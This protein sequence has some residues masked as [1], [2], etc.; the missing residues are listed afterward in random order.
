MCI[1]GK[2]VAILKMYLQHDKSYEDTVKL[3]K[4]CVEYLQERIHDSIAVGKTK[5]AQVFFKPVIKNWCMEKCGIRVCPSYK[6]DD[7]RAL[8]IMATFPDGSGYEIKNML[9]HGTYEEVAAY[10]GREDIV[11]EMIERYVYFSEKIKDKD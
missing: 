10:L 7:I 11:E 4:A 3:C 9:L 1:I 2:G 6:G 5:G 8:E